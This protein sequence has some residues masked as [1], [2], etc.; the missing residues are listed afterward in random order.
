MC[1]A[2]SLSCRRPL[3]D[4]A[5]VDFPEATRRVTLGVIVESIQKVCGFMGCQREIVPTTLF[6]Q[7]PSDTICRS[8]TETDEAGI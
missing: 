7:L 6:R 8:P 3:D 4:A 2:A 1:C 5:L